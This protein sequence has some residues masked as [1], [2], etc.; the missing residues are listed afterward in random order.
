MAKYGQEC[1]RILPPFVAIE[2]NEPLS[3]Y[4]YFRNTGTLDHWLWGFFVDI[5]LYTSNEYITYVYPYIFW[6]IISEII[7][8]FIA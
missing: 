1:V 3:G 7:N 2:K 5:L 6:G 8:T 4:R